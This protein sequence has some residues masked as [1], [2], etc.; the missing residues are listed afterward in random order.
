MTKEF[1]KELITRYWN[2]HLYTIE[3]MKAFVDSDWISPEYFTELTGEDYPEPQ[4]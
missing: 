1:K 4:A 3:Q 2:F